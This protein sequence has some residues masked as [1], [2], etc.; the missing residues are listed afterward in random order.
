MSSLKR[1]RKSSAKQINLLRESI[2]SGEG[3]FA[4]TSHNRE[5]FWER[6]LEITSLSPKVNAPGSNTLGKAFLEKKCLKK[7]CY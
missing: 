6:T 4:K 1:R 2:V 7:T 5:L 3:L